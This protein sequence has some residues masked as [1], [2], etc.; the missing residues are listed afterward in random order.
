M[1]LFRAFVSLYLSLVNGES[2]HTLRCSF[3]TFLRRLSLY[4]IGVSWCIVTGRQRVVYWSRRP[5]HGL[6]KELRLSIGDSSLPHGGSFKTILTLT[7]LLSFAFFLE[8]CAYS[9]AEA[10][11]KHNPSDFLSTCNLIAAAVSGA[12]QVFFPRECVILSL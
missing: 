5:P 3:F 1:A 10:L 2:T 8:L 9:W 12:S 7:L 11:E 4:I 6:F